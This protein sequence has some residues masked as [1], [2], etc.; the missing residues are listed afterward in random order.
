MDIY[1]TLSFLALMGWIRLVRVFLLSFTLGYSPTTQYTAFSP[2]I[3]R[4][5]MLISVH[6]FVVVGHNYAS[7]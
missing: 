6:C 4:D 5:R 3:F 2:A 7:G 1:G